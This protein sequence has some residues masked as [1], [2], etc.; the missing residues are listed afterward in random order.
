MA[1]QNFKVGNRKDDI[2]LLS[3]I[4]MAFLVVL[5]LATP[6]GNKFI[7]VCFWGH[8]VQYVVTRI[9]DKNAT[10]EYKFYW[11]NA[12]Y[13]AKMNDKRAL[14]M[15]DRAIETMPAYLYERDVQNMYLDRAKI[16]CM[17]KDYI[18]SLN[19]YFKST[20]LSNDDILRIALMFKMQNKNSLAVSY[21]N[22]LLNYELGFQSGCACIA[23]VYAS[24][25]KVSQS[26]KL[27]DYLVTKDPDEANYYFVRAQ[28]KKIK[29]D[30]IGERNDLYLAKLKDPDVD[31]KYK[32]IADV[33]L[34]KNINLSKIF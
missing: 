34:A 33:L 15:M 7:Q 6:P 20:S 12:L 8:N 11:K 10:E 5:W 9:V 31:K 19:D 3:I 13:L 4:V 16:R 23:D 29:G 30:K 17:F 1:I 14:T 21:C 25:G 24:A 26:I 32:P 22:K 28:Y 2:K 27:Y 18:G